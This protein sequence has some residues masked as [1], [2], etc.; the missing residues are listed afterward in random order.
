MVTGSFASTFHGVARATQD[1]DIVIDP[2]GVALDAFLAS[3]DPDGYYVDHL[4]ALGDPR[5]ELIALDLAPREDQAWHKRRRA[6]LQAWP[7]P[8][9]C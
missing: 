8:D 5:G 6:L 9:R 1:L 2:P 3:L 7:I 4:Q